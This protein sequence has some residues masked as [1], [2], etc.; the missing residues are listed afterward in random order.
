MKGYRHFVPTTLLIFALTALLAGLYL[1]AGTYGAPHS[2][3]VLVDL[4]LLGG[5]WLYA[6]T[7]PVP[8][9]IPV[10]VPRPAG[11]V[12]LKAVTVPVRR[13]WRVPTRKDDEDS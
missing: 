8:V 1:H 9:R 6:Q 4:A 13:D 11:S 12:R 7:R 3:A 5:A 2:T 10:F